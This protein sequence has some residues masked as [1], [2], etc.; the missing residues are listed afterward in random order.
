MITHGGKPVT[1]LPGLIAMSASI[2]PP[3]TQVK[4]VPAMI[5]FGAAVP[6]ATI[7]AGGMEL[8]VTVAV[9]ESVPTVA[10]TVFANMPVAAPDVNRP[11]L[12]SM[13]PPPFTTAHVGD[14]A[15]MLPFASRPVA[16]NC[17][18]ELVSTE[19]GFGVTVIVAS[20]PLVTL[21]VAKPARLSTLAR[22]VLA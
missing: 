15:M 4:A 18:V 7:G 20:G 1:V 17:C 19:A 5:P 8:T 12:R 13:R 16:A 2:R 10:S 6:S 9:A 3:V 11:V 21:T 22:T 14:T